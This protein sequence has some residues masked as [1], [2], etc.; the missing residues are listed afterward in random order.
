MG[1][2]NYSTGQLGRG[3]AMPWWWAPAHPAYKGP[4]PGEYDE[5]AQPKQ[6]VRTR[7]TPGIPWSDPSELGQSQSDRINLRGQR[8]PNNYGPSN[9]RQKQSELNPEG[10]LDSSVPYPGQ[11]GQPSACTKPSGL[12]GGLEAFPLLAKFRNL[13]LP[14]R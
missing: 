9:V 4:P 12:L 7:S 5:L 14:R 11:Q 2:S 10:T 13:L 1:L 3:K 6:P 8:Y